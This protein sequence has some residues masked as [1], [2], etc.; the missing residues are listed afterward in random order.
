MDM[1]HWLG[2]D[3]FRIDGRV[4]VYF[5]PWNLG[6]GPPA[7]DIIC[8]SHDHYDH[9]SPDDV[10]KITQESTVV[11][12]TPGVAA[13]CKGAVKGLKPGDRGE[14]H[15]VT[16]NCIAAYNVNKAFHPR[17][18][19]HLGFIVDLDGFRI[20]HAGDTD[21]IP[22]MDGLSVDVALLPVS[23]T[24]VMSAEEAVEA[25]NRIKPRVAVPMH[26]GSIVGSVE[27]AK[28]FKSLYGGETLILE[29]E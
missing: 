1:I 20:Y 4:T 19:A 21:L 11:F 24:Y 17:E 29:K 7:A 6:D 23:G 10:E 9:F 3:S 27:D 22:E 2:H 28:R 14:A 16:I 13:R 26:Y 15:G 25:A 8:I 12:T 5:D 18:E